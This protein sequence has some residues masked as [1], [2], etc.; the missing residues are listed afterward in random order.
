MP[1]NSKHYSID[2]DEVREIQGYIM[3]FLD[4]CSI[5]LSE[6]DKEQANIIAASYVHA[7]EF[8]FRGIIDAYY[9]D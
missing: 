8:Q 9:G 4:R 6:I 1:A 2:T 5:N 3:D 7:I